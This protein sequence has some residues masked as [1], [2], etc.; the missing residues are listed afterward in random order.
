[1]Y[2]TIALAAVMLV[3]ALN[4]S[5]Q[6]APASAGET[7]A[8]AKSV[9]QAND[10]SPRRW[11]VASHKGLHIH[12]APAADA[13]VIKTIKDGEVLSNLGC[14]RAGTRKWCRVQPLR[15][16]IRG[17]VEAEALRPA[18]GPDGT[19]PMGADD[20]AGRAR[21][22]DFDA[23][24][25]LRCAQIR[26]QKLAECKFGVARSDGGD[27]TVLITFA[28]GFRRT[29]YFAHG[30]FIRANSTMSGTGYDTDWRV[31][32]EL[33][34]IRVDDQRYELLGRDIFGK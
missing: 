34:I 21:Q 3:L 25:S 19:V 30:V 13:K 32:G 2:R 6:V 26:G 10:G 12:N 4:A 24:G 27:A 7:E 33:H 11:Q 5:A 1:M 23:T 18:R 9:A 15:S 20:S 22:G 17:Y 16:R 31:E 8:A 28:N 29:L 14:E